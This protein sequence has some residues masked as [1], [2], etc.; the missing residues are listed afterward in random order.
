M[1]ADLWSVTSFNEL[2]REGMS[3]ERWNL[4]H[5]TQPRRMSHIETCPAGRAGPVIASSDYMRAFA[6]Q[7]RAY[8]PRRYITWVPTVSVAAITGFS[9]AASSR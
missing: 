4:L 8:L 6:D 9:C 2:R 3:T 5:P 1:S 7:V